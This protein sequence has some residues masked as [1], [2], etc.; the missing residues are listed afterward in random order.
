MKKLSLL[1]LVV[2]LLLLCAW[3]AAAQPAP[4]IY[5]AA[6]LAPEGT[7]GGIRGT[8]T[9]EHAGSGTRV[10]L[11]IQGLTSGSQTTAHIHKGSCAG[12]VIASLAPAAAT[13]QGSAQATTQIS[14]TLDFTAGESWY[15]DLHLPADKSAGG[16]LCGRFNP[17]V[18]GGGQ[19]PP[20]TTPP[21]IPGTGRADGP[22]LLALAGLGLTLLGS[23]LLARRRRGV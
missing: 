17:A 20:P 12:A 16:T 10:T 7:T 14:A 1:A 15:V 19:L 11:L 18:A 13:A 21:G 5:S 3:P 23:G 22:L 4:N 8:A 6:D 9:L 2:A